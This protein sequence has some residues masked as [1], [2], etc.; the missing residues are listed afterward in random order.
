MSYTCTCIPYAM[1][2][3]GSNRL[4]IKWILELG[5]V[6]T[7]FDAGFPYFQFLR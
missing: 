2:S 3:A 5:I 4:D 6:S 1:I 7:E